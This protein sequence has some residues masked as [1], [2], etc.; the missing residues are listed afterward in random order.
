V[1]QLSRPNCSR[2]FLVPVS[3]QV[4]DAAVRAWASAEYPVAMDPGLPVASAM[5]QAASQ[6]CGRPASS[7][8]CAASAYT[9]QLARQNW[10]RQPRAGCSIARDLI[11]ARAQ[12][13][14]K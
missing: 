1:L 11:L 12:G 10:T 6:R 7:C 3:V 2:S 13:H 9:A 4:R 14:M 8:I 5:V